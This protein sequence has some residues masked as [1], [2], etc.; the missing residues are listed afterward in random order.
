MPT[1]LLKICLCLKKKTFPESWIL[2]ETADCSQISR[3]SMSQAGHRYYHLFFHKIFT[4]SQ[5]LVLSKHLSYL[6]VIIS[7]VYMFQVNEHW[8]VNIFFH[9]LP[10]DVFLNSK[11]IH[12]LKYWYSNILSRYQQWISVESL[13]SNLKT[14]IYS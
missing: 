9:Y 7:V 10:N 11:K 3:S 4:V 2:R 1:D 8:I 14:T 12:D 6:M 5:L 13:T